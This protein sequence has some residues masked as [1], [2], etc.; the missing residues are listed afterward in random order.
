MR[1]KIFVGDADSESFGHIFEKL[2]EKFGDQYTIVKEKCQ[3]YIQKTM[4]TALRELKKKKK[5][6]K[7]IDGKSIGGRNRLTDNVI[8]KIQNHY[9]L[10]IRGN[11][12]D[13]D[14]MVSNIW[15]V[16]K[17]NIKNDEESLPQQHSNCPKLS[18]S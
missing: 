18:D 16:Y 17:H 7:L 10:A 9:G 14:G 13:L 5:G 6:M 11:F 15:A 1:Y 2:Q 4:G 12:G 3:G 8:D